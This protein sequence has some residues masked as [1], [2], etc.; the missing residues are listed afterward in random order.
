MNRNATQI[1]SQLR[2]DCTSERQA[3]TEKAGRQVPLAHEW[4]LRDYRS[5]EAVL[6]TAKYA[7]TRQE[8]H[9]ECFESIN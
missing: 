1:Q 2:A 4:V 8:T 7:A 3:K 6:A 9:N 5:W